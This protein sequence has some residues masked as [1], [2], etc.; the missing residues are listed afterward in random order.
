MADL[1]ISILIP[2]YNEGAESLKN[3]RQALLPLIDNKM[4]QRSYRWQVMLVDD[5]SRDDSLEEMRRL[6]REDSRFQYLSLSRNFGKENAMLAGMDAVSGNC[7]VIMDADLQHPI[8]TI[9]DMI[10]KWE[11]GYDDVYGRRVDRGREPWLRRRLSLAYYSLL[12]RM[13]PRVPIL[14]NVGDFRLLDRRVVNAIRSM[15]ETQRYTKGLYCWVGFRKTD[16]PFV[17]RGRAAGQSSFSFWRLFNLAIEGITSY[18]TAPL[19][20][21]T[22][23]GL[24]AA[25]CAILYMLYIVAKTI[26]VGEPVAGFP[27]LVCLILFIGG[28]QLL[29]IGIIGEYIG[30]I[31]LQT[32]NRPPYIIAE[33]NGEKDRDFVNVDDCNPDD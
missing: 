19:R 5:G 30:R 16:V 11:E 29:A 32:K 8:E 17:Q 6:H 14:P 7:T 24:I 31:F 4:T 18:T 28:C 2:V 3:L 10:A 13:S 23:F 15:R 27:T 33:K 9:P 21:A 12:Q 26:F 22:V 20:I 25:L 1:L